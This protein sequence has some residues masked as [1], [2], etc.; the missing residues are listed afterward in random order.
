MSE[1]SKRLRWDIRLGQFGDRMV[2]AIKN[3]VVGMR[4]L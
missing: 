3:L 1:D 4:N 2:E